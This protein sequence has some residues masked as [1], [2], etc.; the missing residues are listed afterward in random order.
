M[1]NFYVNF[2]TR[3]PDRDTVSNC[4]RAAK[5]TAFVSPTI[6]NVTVFF[7]EASDTQDDAVI[8]ALGKHASKD[9]RSPV[10]AILNHDDDFLSYWL[11]DA[12][13]CVDQYNSC[14][15]YF[16]GGDETPAGGDAKK[17]CEAFGTPEKVNEVDKILRNEEYVFA[18]DRH[19][20]LAGEL[21]LPW[22]YVCMGYRYV[23]EDSLTPG[24]SK[25]D[26]AR[27]E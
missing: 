18:L 23:N 19:K 2:A 11:F 3:G 13:N 8:A 24:L 14:P 4:L 9:L 6:E 7:D 21:N 15:G 5:R 17:L 27:V 1:G 25:D 20:D 16:D 10:F 12:G 22:A 26:L